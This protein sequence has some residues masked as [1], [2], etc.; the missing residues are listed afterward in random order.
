MKINVRNLLAAV[1]ISAA[2]A[3]T[4]CSSSDDNAAGLGITPTVDAGNVDGNV[5]ANADAKGDAQVDGAAG[6]AGSGYDC[7]KCDTPDTRNISL[8][9]YEG[10]N[11]PPM[12]EGDL[13]K[14]RV[15]P[16]GEEYEFKVSYQADGKVLLASTGDVTAIY[17]VDGKTVTGKATITISD[18][19]DMA[20]HPSKIAVGDKEWNVD[21]VENARD[22]KD[23]NP[24][25]K[26]GVWVGNPATLTMAKDILADNGTIQL[27][28]GK[29]DVKVTVVGA[30]KG[31][32]VKVEGKA[33][34]GFVND[35]AYVFNGKLGSYADGAVELGVMNTGT[36]NSNCYVDSLKLTYGVAEVPVE[37]GHTHAFGDETLTSVK[38]LDVVYSDSGKAVGKLELSTS[39]LTTSVVLRQDKNTEESD[40]VKI[41]GKVLKVTG[42]ERAGSCV[43]PDAKNNTPSRQMLADYRDMVKNAKPQECRQTAVGARVRPG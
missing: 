14:L 21:A 43:A 13:V 4:G 28:D 17:P 22:T 18:A 8:V 12:K 25:Y 41:D 32:F 42:A 31:A 3:G 38:V 33:G 19:A 20:T 9:S 26:T 37:V 6:S 7:T 15:Q 24:S 35:S 36:T 1:G 40:Q 23:A 5:D 2:V 34:N 11:L 27:T 10:V 30:D 39:G 29:V 16:G